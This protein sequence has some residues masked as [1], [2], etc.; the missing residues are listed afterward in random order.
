MKDRRDFLSAAVLALFFPK[1]F[2]K[3]KEPDEIKDKFQ[4]FREACLDY[5]RHHLGANNWED[6]E[7]YLAEG[8]Q[9]AFE[10][11]IENETT[12]GRF[13]NPPEMFSGC[14]T[15]HTAIV[16]AK[17]KARPTSDMKNPTMHTVHF[18]LQEYGQEMLKSY[19]ELV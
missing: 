15:G 1:A 13:G 2:L 9:L 12:I 4:E 5:S 16:M 11:L 17:R 10:E 3:D 14:V 18:Y 7:D 6:L 8:W 19:R